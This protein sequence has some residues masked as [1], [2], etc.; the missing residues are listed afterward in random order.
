MS[1]DLFGNSVSC[2]GLKSAKSCKILCICLFPAEVVPKL[3]F[4]NNSK[5]PI[6]PDSGIRLEE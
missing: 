4:P 6:L 2:H 5:Q 1:M 3:K